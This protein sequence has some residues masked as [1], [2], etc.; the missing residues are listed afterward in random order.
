MPNVT[1]AKY[2]KNKPHLADLMKAYKPP[3]RLQR[4]SKWMKGL[5][6]KLHTEKPLTETEQARRE[7]AIGAATDAWTRDFPGLPVPSHTE[8]LQWYRKPPI[9]K[10]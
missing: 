8:L 3:T 10:L 6:A 5:V 9:L 1:F 7:L 2:G 4:L